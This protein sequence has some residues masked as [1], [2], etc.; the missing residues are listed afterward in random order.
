MNLH[1]LDLLA[2]KILVGL[3]ITAIPAVIVL[4]G[5][6]ATQHVLETPQGNAA[7]THQKG[8]P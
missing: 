7:G 6:W 1:D 3:A 4:A 2:R 5:L 8:R